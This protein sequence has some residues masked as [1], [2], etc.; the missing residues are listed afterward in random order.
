M[1]KQK[2]AAIAMPAAPN[3]FRR[4]P[5][6]SFLATANAAAE[7]YPYAT[8]APRFD[9]ST[10]QPV[11]VRPKK[12]IANETHITNSTAFA[13]VPSRFS[14]PNQLGTAPPFDI[15]C[16]RRLEA[17]SVPKIPVSCAASIAAP[18]TTTPAPPSAFFDAAKTGIASIPRRL[19]RSSRYSRHEAYPPGSDIAGRSARAR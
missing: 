1:R 13:G 9:T 17:T 12:G 15:A 14:L 7:V 6:F 18:I 8:A 3:A 11:T 4:A 5:A 16:M 2:T 19:G 10:G